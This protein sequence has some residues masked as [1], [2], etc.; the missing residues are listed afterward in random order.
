[1]V[2]KDS[3][4]ES[5]QRAA[6]DYASKACGKIQ[7][8]RQNTQAHRAVIREDMTV[9]QSPG[10]P[11]VMRLGPQDDRSS[12]GCFDAVLPQAG[13]RVVVVVLAVEGAMVA[14]DILPLLLLGSIISPYVF[15]AAPQNTNAAAADRACE[16]TPR[17]SM[18][19]RMVM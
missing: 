5:V 1:M 12:K 15:T 10:V 3:W 7:L 17:D 8:M 2:V 19:V 18:T 13:V 6:R 14:G 9:L 4:I 11:D 16:H